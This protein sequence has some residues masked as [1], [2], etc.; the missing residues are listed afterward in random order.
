VYMCVCMG[1]N[2]LRLIRTPSGRSGVVT[3]V[4]RP[5]DDSRRLIGVLRVHVAVWAVVAL[6]LNG[7]RVKLIFKCRIGT[8]DSQWH[9]DSCNLR[10][11]AMCLRW[12]KDGQQWGS[13]V[14]DF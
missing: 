6:K 14:P 12:H 8:D 1:G 5:T 4:R 9:T 10:L 11:T 3:N 7:T 13:Q 2:P